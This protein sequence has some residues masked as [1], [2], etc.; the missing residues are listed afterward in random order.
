MTFMK[1]NSCSNIIIKFRDQMDLF[2][3]LSRKFSEDGKV[4]HSYEEHWKNC[5]EKLQIL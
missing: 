2:L 1:R 4:M 5:I 3:M